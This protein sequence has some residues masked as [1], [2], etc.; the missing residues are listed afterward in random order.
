M[1]D[2]MLTATFDPTLIEPQQIRLLS[3]REYD[4]LVE[5]DWFVDEPPR[6]GSYTS[7]QTLRDGDALRPTL[8]PAVAISVADIPR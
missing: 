4:R 8:L 3:R 2:F 1:V 7:V 6:G 5:L